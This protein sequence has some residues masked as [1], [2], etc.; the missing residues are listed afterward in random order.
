[1]KTIVIIPAGGAG[2][3]LKSHIAK[4]YLLLDSVPVLVHTLKVFQ[5]SKEID[6]II[7]AL[8]LDDLVYIRQE[9]IE[10]Y[11]LTKVVNIVAGGNDRQD[12][13]KNCLM[14]IEGKCDLVVIHDAVRPFI[15]EEL[16]K[17]VIDAAKKTGAALAG[18]KAKDTIKEIKEGNIIDATVPRN[19]LWMAQT[20][21][22]FEYELIKQAYKKAYDDKFYGTDDACLV[23]RMGKKVI[24]VESSY[25]NIK[26]TTNEDM[27][28]A[29]ALMK[30]RNKVI[31]RSGIG[32]DSH[33][34]IA[35]RKLILG[36]MEI[37]YDKG[38]DGHSDADVIIHAICD[39]VLGASG[40]KDI[41]RH[42]PDNDPEFK[43]ISS[44]II[45]EKVNEIIAA[46]GF[47]INNIDATVVM[48]TPKL[49]PHTAKMVSNLA[50]VLNIPENCVSIK[51]K[52]NE[53]MG[54]VGRN[55]GVAVFAT[56]MLTERKKDG[57][58]A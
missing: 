2:K 13:V 44:M 43:D 36:G 58:K 8:P 7:I 16:I 24:M 9:L 14:A 51:A 48:E 29:E 42:F 52:T 4:Q 12:S 15:T 55:E 32:Y 37:P 10:K 19:N 20:P 49:A 40:I 27:L 22:V 53:G 3:R 34:F 6:E 25:K 47:S 31:L 26:I 18:I 17:Q 28:V 1:M 39:A 11:E 41:G 45:L 33:R 21:Q 30:I 46:E 54:F 35:G 38:L 50:R 56:A 23:E 57:S 5:N